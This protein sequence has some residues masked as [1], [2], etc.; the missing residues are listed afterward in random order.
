MSFFFFLGG[1]GGGGV[2]EGVGIQVGQ[3]SCNKH[4]LNS[5]SFRE[6]EQHISKLLEG[7]GQSRP[8]RKPPCLKHRRLTITSNFKPADDHADA[9]GD[10]DSNSSSTVQA[11]RVSQ[12]FSTESQ[13][14]K[15]VGKDGFSLLDKSAVSSTK[16]VS[17]TNSKDSFCVWTGHADSSSVSLDTLCAFSSHCLKTLRL[18][19][20]AWLRR[21]SSKTVT[22]TSSPSC[23][24]P[25]DTCDDSNIQP[26]PSSEGDSLTSQLDRKAQPYSS[27]SGDRMPNLHGLSS[28]MD[29]GSAETATTNVRARTIQTRLKTGDLGCANL[30]MASITQPKSPSADKTGGELTAKAKTIK[31]T[32]RSLSEPSTS[33]VRDTD[34]TPGRYRLRKRALVSTKEKVC[35]TMCKDSV[36]VVVDVSA[37]A[38]VGSACCNDIPHAK[39]QELSQNGKFC[40][41]VTC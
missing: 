10:V 38:A 23:L 15:C 40:V 24:S 2:G 3:S 13:G 39:H 26:N 11:V 16:H 27:S 8:L 18:K 12:P 28:G 14:G 9:D 36:V 34:F 31:Q 30:G 35:S 17:A 5:V 4:V 32:N 22:S 25:M 29:L 19:K 6:V 7:S 33:S 41:Y 21:K 37:D 1:G 20:S